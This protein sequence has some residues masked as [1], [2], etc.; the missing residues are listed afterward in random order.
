[1]TARTVAWNGADDPL[2][3]RVVVWIRV[4]QISRIMGASDDYIL[5]IA[6][7]VDG[8]DRKNSKNKGRNERE[9]VGRSPL[10]CSLQIPVPAAPLYI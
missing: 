4:G 3:R 8:C 1:M 7:R 9:H 6:M 2:G 5:D 10:G